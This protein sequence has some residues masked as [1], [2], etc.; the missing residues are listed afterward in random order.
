M[1][2]FFGKLF[3]G[4]VRSILKA[5]ETGDLDK[6][7]ELISQ[8]PALVNAKGGNGE[9]PLFKAIQNGNLEMMNFLLSQRA[10]VNVQD[11]NDDTPLHKAAL[12]VNEAMVKLLLEHGADV[13]IKG[14]FS[15]SPLHCASMNADVRVMELLIDRGADIQAKNDHGLSPLHLA[16]FGKADAVRLLLEKGADVNAPGEWETMTPLYFLLLREGNAIDLDNVVAVLK[17]YGSINQPW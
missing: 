9:T 7:K 12:L 8:D 16:A 14:M 13:N 5:A 3:G 17:E 4:V 15:R 1:S 11:K 10:D 6:V 2:D